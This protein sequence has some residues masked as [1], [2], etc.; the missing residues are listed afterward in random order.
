[1]IKKITAL[2][3]FLFT[4]ALTTPFV[5]AQEDFIFDQDV[6]YRGEKKVV[7]LP[8]DETVDKD[9]F[10]AGE[11]VEISG[12]VNGDVYAA[13]GEVIVNGTVNGDLIAAGGTVEVSGNVTQDARVAGGQVNISGQVGRNLTVAG[14]NVEITNNAILNGNLVAGAGN[15]NVRAP[16]A[17]DIKAGTGNLVIANKVSGNV[18][19]GTGALRL[20]SNGAVDGDLTYYSNDQLTLAPDATVSGKIT[21][22]Q[23]PEYEGPKPADLAKMLFGV[24]AF[25]KIISLVSTLILGLLLVYLFPRFTEKVSENIQ[26][27]PWASLIVGLVVMIVSPIL[28]LVLLITVFGIPLAFVFLLTFIILMYLTRIFAIYF[29]GDLI[30][31]RLDRDKTKGVWKFI[32]GLLAYFLITLIPFIGELTAFIVLLFGLGSAL[33]TKKEIYSALRKKNTI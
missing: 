19:V 13:G 33:I 25:F 10:A 4:L 1:M 11:V 9:Y 18:E 21:F 7:T 17:K 3:L 32:V 12:T 29:L 23:T 30:M 22:N 27:N 31:E 14:G 26:K 16:I 20:T 5:L 24:A 2:V 28:F 15:I 8:K 6:T